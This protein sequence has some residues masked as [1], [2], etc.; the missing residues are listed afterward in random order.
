MDGCVGEGGGDV[1]WGVGDGAEGGYWDFEDVLVC[2]VNVSICYYSVISERLGVFTLMCS[3]A[4]RPTPRPWR[5]FGVM[6]L[7]TMPF[8]SARCSRFSISVSI[9]TE[10][11]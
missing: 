1:L 11:L 5:C 10:E 2:L 4:T 7:S 8:E 6:P 9:F 3:V